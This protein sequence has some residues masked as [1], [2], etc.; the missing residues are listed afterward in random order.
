MLIKVSSMALSSRLTA[1]SKVL[2]AKNSL[3]ILECFLFD[4]ADGHI[5]VTASDAEKSFIT[6]LPTIEQ[7]GGGRFCVS[8]RKMMDTVRELPEQPLTLDI[9]E[10]NYEIKGSHATGSFS[11]MGQSAD[12]YP[13]PRPVGDGE[14]SRVV[15][16]AR[17]IIN[18]LNRTLFAT[19]NDE[20]RQVMNGVYFDMHG[21][22]M[23]FAATDGRK[24]V[25]DIVLDANPGTE[26]SFIM[27]KKVATILKGTL[28]MNDTEV[29]IRYMSD[30][31]TIITP[32][33]T[34]HF[35]LIEGTYP[36]YNA[37]IPQNNPF[38]ATIDRQS[39]ASALKRV[40]VFC[41]QASGLVKVELN[42]GTIRLTGQ[43]HAY[44]TSGEEILPCDYSGNH[45]AIGFSCQ[46]M[47][48]ICNILESDGVTIELADPARPGVIKPDVQPDNEELLMLLMPM[49]VDD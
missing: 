9:N 5:T 33:M 14:G 43:D 44:N 15:L 21:D 49:R 38:M 10:E 12:P 34:M 27:P 18:G 16:P 30:R 19:A 39:L 26:G 25:K 36:N 48:E 20:I 3:P 42:D 17:T 40:L 47:L 7:I 41:N 31:A 24:L 23:V 13:T 22:H 37:V 45:I 2:A 8:A 28:A 4:V 32:D 1:A 46:F 35:T 29:K 6:T 11:I